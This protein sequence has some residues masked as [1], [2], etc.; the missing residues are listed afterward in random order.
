SPQFPNAE[1]V[2]PL[3]FRHRNIGAADRG[4]GVGCCRT[5][6]VVDAPR[7][8]TSRQEEEKN[9]RPPGGRVLAHF[10]KHGEPKSRGGKRRRMIGRGSRGSKKSQA[11]PPMFV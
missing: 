3:K 4:H 6:H 9:R 5:E 11:V 7:S 1:L 10:L 2:L 8:E